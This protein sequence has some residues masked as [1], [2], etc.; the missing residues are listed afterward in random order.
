MGP[1]LSVC[2]PTHN[3]ADLLRRTLRSLAAIQPCP[4][5]AWEIIVVA[6]CC[7]DDTL[8]VVK[9]IAPEIRVPLVLLEEMEKGVVAARNRAVRQASGEIIAFLDDDVQV[10][11]LWLRELLNTFDAEQ[12][13]VMVG[14]IYLD[15]HGLSKPMWFDASMGQYLAQVDLGD[16]PMLLQN[17]LGAAANLAITRDMLQRTGEFRCPLERCGKRTAG[18]DTDL[19]AR[20]MRLNG[21]VLYAPAVTVSHYVAPARLTVRYLRGVAFDV[22]MAEYLMSP[23]VKPGELAAN[24]VKKIP[25]LIER[26]LRWLLVFPFH[27]RAAA[28]L[29]VSVAKTRGNIRGLLLCICRGVL[30]RR[31]IVPLVR[32]GLTERP[33]KIVSGNLAVPSDDFMP[34]PHG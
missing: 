23:H 8:R 26:S 32:A 25:R 19:I 12:P 22:G 20:A 17:P 7:E 16:I 1:R 27:R 6:N 30:R 21:R 24:L 3:R 2:I 34:R 15:W 9:N 10:S 33:A 18:E 5:V 13:D 14:R 31:T 28:H 11:P 4:G 29:R